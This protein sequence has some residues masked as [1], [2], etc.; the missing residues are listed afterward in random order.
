MDNPTQSSGSTFNVSVAIADATNRLL[1]V[2]RRDS[3]RWTLPG[4]GV[5][6]REG[7]LAAAGREV[8]EETGMP[9]SYYN[10]AEAARDPRRFYWEPCDPRRPYHQEPSSGDDCNSSPQDNHHKLFFWATL[11]QP[12]E[13]PDYSQHP[14]QDPDIECAQ[15]V[16]LAD[17]HLYFEAQMPEVHARAIAWFL[18]NIVS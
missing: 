6:P 5:H 7:H 2:K 3:G 14:P 18:K 13:L 11:I 1:L 9:V 12:F 10:L 16:T 17:Y 15:W 4:G 8:E